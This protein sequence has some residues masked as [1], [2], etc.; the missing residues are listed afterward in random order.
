MFTHPKKETLFFFFGAMLYIHVSRRVTWSKQHKSK[1]CVNS[2]L[3]SV[4]ENLQ[5]SSENKT[6]NSI[7]TIAHRFVTGEHAVHS[8]SHQQAWAANTLLTLQ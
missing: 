3:P 2:T 4:C 1:P 6:K 5:E 8:L 7:Y